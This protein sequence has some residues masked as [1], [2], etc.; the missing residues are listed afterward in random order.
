MID[1]WSVPIGYATDAVC[2][3]AKLLLN[4]KV[5][6]IDVGSEYTKLETTQGPLRA[7]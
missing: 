7:R 2:R 3:G 1:A 6:S 4:H 5:L